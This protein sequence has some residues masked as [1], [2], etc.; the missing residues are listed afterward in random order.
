MNYEYNVAYD[1]VNKGSNIPRQTKQDEEVEQ[2]VMIIQLLKL[3]RDRKDTGHGP[4]LC[5]Q[6]TQS[7]I[8]SFIKILIQIMLKHAMGILIEK[9]HTR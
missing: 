2:E 1:V 8:S 6:Q 7:V 4:M 3:E 5:W 9:Y